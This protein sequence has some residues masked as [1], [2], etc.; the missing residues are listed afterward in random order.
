MVG[1]VAQ[2]DAADMV[3]DGGGDAHQSQADRP[4]LPPAGGGGGQGEHLGEGE[5]VAG[6]GHDQAPDAV[7]RVPLQGEAV[8]AERGVAPLESEARGAP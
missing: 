5:D 3:G 6:Q 4:G 7:G 2:D 8:E 1:L